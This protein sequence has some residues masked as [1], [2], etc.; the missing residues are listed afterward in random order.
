MKIEIQIAK[1]N[2][3][4]AT[5]EKA[6]FWHKAIAKEHKQ[7]CQRWLEFLNQHRL[8]NEEFAKKKIIDLKTAIKIYGDAG[9]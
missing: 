9:I 3:I 2:V 6:K 5:I 7:T 4:N 1:E 8:I